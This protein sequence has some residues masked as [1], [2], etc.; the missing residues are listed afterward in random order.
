MSLFDPSEILQVPTWKSLRVS[1]AGSLQPTAMDS[2]E[3]CTLDYLRGAAWR[4]LAH[5][6]VT[7]PRADPKQ[8][9]RYGIGRAVGLDREEPPNWGK[10]TAAVP[11]KPTAAVPQL[12]FLLDPSLLLYSGF[13]PGVSRASTYSV[14]PPEILRCYLGSALLLGLIPGVLRY[15]GIPQIC[16]GRSGL[17]I[18]HTVMKSHR[19]EIFLQICI[20]ETCG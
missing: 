3:V 2:L 16:T 15:S 1:L 12:G 4:L 7:W 9:R 6:K 8:H 10:P 18:S 14:S 17:K 19:F 20:P 13:R 11:V 5:L